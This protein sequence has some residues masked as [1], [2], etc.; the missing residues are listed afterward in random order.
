MALPLLLLG[1]AALIA[2]GAGV[3][4]GVSAKGDFDEAER[5]NKKAKKTLKRAKKSLKQQRHDTQEGLEN[6]GRQKVHLHENGLKPFVAAFSR[7]KNVD[8]AGMT[9]GEDSQVAQVTE[10]ETLDI[11]RTVTEMEELV[12][13][14]GAALGAGALAGYATY[15]SVGLLGTASTGTAITGLSGAA[16]ANATLAWLG[17]GSLAAGGAGMAAGAAVLGGIVAA[18]VLLIGGLV[19]KSKATGALEDAKSNLKKARASAKAMET[20]EVAADA[21]LQ[22]ANE[23]WQVLNTLQC[24]HLDNALPKLER[25]VSANA[26]YSSYNNDQKHLVMHTAAVAKTAHLVSETPLFDEDGVVTKEIRRALKKANS[27]LRAIS[28]I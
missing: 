20:A 7:I 24:D 26:D 4:A 22:K 11:Q 17:G 25:L 19:M 23:V 2:G 14:G 10:V 27:F 1:G 6:L 13:P 8:Y 21:I 16:A 9:L 18:P 3:A 12:G 28:A 5:R 15:G